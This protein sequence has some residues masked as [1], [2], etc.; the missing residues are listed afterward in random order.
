MRRNG[1]PHALA[2]IRTGAFTIGYL[3]GSITAGAHASDPEKTSWR[4][5]T[6][7]WLRRRFPQ[8]RWYGL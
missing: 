4:A 8:V 2:R 3:G 1:L 5:L 7:A 6:T